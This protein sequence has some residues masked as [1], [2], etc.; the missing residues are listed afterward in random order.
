MKRNTCVLTE[1][2]IQTVKQIGTGKENSSQ[3]L[4]LLNYKF[5]S[6]PF[7]IDQ[8][9]H[10]FHKRPMNKYKSHFTV[11]LRERTISKKLK[12]IQTK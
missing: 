2:A 5:N 11:L 1:L 10:S 6:A 3:P 7:T 8:P 4:H 9:S 12:P